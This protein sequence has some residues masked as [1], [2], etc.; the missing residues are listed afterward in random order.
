MS[1]YVI[2]PITGDQIHGAFKVVEPAEGPDVRERK[3]RLTPEE[4][5]RLA[6][7]INGLV[8]TAQL[9]LWFNPLS[10]GNRFQAYGQ[11]VTL[12]DMPVQYALRQEGMVYPASNRHRSE[13]FDSDQLLAA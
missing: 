3:R 11:P 6:N 5:A 7:V 13:A 10:D 1:N 9:A 4:E 8:D 12:D 2:A